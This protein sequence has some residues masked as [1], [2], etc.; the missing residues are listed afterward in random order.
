MKG[1]G[2]GA[3]PAPSPLPWPPEVELDDPRW[4]VYEDWLALVRPDIVVDRTELERQDDFAHWLRNG[5]G[6]SD[7]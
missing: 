4:Q 5:G 7:G 1:E 2:E 6:D 3:N